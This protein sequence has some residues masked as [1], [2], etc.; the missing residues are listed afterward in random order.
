MS[1]VNNLRRIE[2]P[3]RVRRTEKTNNGLPIDKPAPDFVFVVFEKSWEFFAGNKDEDA[4]WLPQLRRI[5]ATPGANGVGEDFSLA[6]PLASVR[7]KGGAV[8]DPEDA[9]LGEFQYYV[10]YYETQRKGAKHHVFCELEGI[11]LRSG[12][13]I[14]RSDDAQP[15]WREFRKVIRDSGIV[16]LMTHEVF[17][18]KM[19]TARDR[20]S[21]VETRYGDKPLL[22]YKIDA[23]R[24]LNAAMQA[25]WDKMTEADIETAPV[26]KPKRKRAKK[27]QPQRKA[28]TPPVEEAV[29]P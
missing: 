22:Q 20:L 9:R 21:R 16:P 11:K 2:Q 24:A 23:A 28:N 12:E 15:K 14:W 26:T 18:L 17:L 1:T 10:A 19:E 8:V 6:K 7:E 27:L 13:I 4:A 29:A 5:S 3:T 25:S